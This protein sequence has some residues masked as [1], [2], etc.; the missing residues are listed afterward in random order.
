MACIKGCVKCMQDQGIVVTADV[1]LLFA[2][3][4]LLPDVSVVC[5]D[6]CAMQSAT[7]S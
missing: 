3:Y 7:F 2:L 6:T 5:S 1:P 4:F